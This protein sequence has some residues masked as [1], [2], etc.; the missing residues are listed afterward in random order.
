MEAELFSLLFFC[1]PV[2][3]KRR[4]KLQ[5][6]PYWTTVLNCVAGQATQ[7]LRVTAKCFARLS[8]RLGV[9]P[10]VRLSVTL[11]ICIKTVQATIKKFLLCAAP[12]TKASNR[13]TS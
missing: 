2:K 1:G 7:F 12:R 9:R 10:C 13:G 6:A 5:T 4:P 11:V 3:I 8:H